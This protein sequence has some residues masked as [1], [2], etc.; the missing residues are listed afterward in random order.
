MDSEQSRTM[1]QELYEYLE[2]KRRRGLKDATLGDYRRTLQRFFDFLD[3]NYPDV[4]EITDITRDVVLS[5]ER[6][7][8]VMK[9]AWGRELSVGRRNKYLLHLK[10]FFQYL[11]KEE[12]IYRNPA[13]NIVLPKER[14]RIVRDVLTVEEMDKLLK[15]CSGHS[16]RSLRD[17]AILELLYST[18]IRADELCNICVE[19]IDFSER[20]LFVRKGKLGNQR[21]VPFGE[22]A[23]YWLGRYLERARPLIEEIE[24]ELVF[25]SFRGRKLNPDILCRIVKKWA[26]EAGIVKNVT[27][28]TFRHSCATHMLKGRADIRY[29]QRQLGHRHISTTEKYLKIEIADLKEIHERCHPREQDDW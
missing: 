8:A 5:Y 13:V 3:E 7:L 19:D 25:V 1:E 2:Y 15:I 20:I 29:V 10:S 4:S 9:D 23:K 11:Q 6:Y 28:H 27:T 21:H 22:S 24:S 12:K 14:M 18:G 17:R 26:K 16:M